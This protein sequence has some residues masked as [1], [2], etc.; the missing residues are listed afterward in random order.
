MASN[1]RE[2]IKLVST[3]VTQKG[4]KTGF[5]YTTLKNK[6]NTTAKLVLRKFDPLAWDAQ[7]SKHGMY[8]EFKEDKIK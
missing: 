4:K 6:R 3:G 2:K 8:I 7:K 1:V 5:Y